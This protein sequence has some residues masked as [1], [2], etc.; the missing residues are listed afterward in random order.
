MADDTDKS[1]KTEEPT[2]KKLQDARD[3]GQV[4]SSRE[5]NH[6]FM[7]LAISIIF[8]VLAD[9]M[10]GDIART[11]VKFI[12][13]PDSLPTDAGGLNAVFTST[14][15][16]IGMALLPAMIILVLAALASGFMQTGFIASV[17]RIQPKLE[18]ISIIKGAERLFSM[19]AVVEFTKGVLK[20]AIVGSVATMVILPQFD[21]MDRLMTIPAIEFLGELQ[22][23]GVKLV[24]AILAVM[25][26]IAVIDFLYQRF[27]HVKG[28]RMSRQ[29]IKDEMKQTEGDPQVK[30]RMK[31]IRTER[32][33]KRM[34]AAVPEA[35]VVITNPTHFA[36][37]LKYDPE[38]MAAPR[39]LAK[40]ADLVA[41]RIRE[42]AKEHDVPI[43][44]NPPLAQ[45]LFAGV[46]IDDE[47]PEEYYKAVAEVISY[48]F[49]LKG[50]R[51]S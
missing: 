30:A 25:T 51:P 39:L 28:M 35:D 15:A 43:V 24:A 8:M 11:L 37:A 18:K 40:G 12:E 4:A 50:W 36:V 29:E 41:Q 27:E 21:G 1:Q 17:D 34:M 49:Q 13:R 22:W 5:I 10:A 44:E 42:L 33:R 7:L 16:D 47:V 14:I 46:E 32:A 23:L 20:I 31:Q 3:K 9:S 48:V 38:N 19:K 2:P 6:W 45:A 26:V